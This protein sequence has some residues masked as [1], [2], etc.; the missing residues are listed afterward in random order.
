M[1]IH[2]YVP[3]QNHPEL[4]LTAIQNWSSRRKVLHMG[5]VV[6]FVSV[7]FWFLGTPQVVTVQLRDDLGMDSDD[8]ALSFVFNFIGLGLAGVGLIPL[9]YRY[10]RRSMYLISAL[11]QIG[12]SIWLGSV[13]TK[14][15]YFVCMLIAGMGASVTQTLVP[16]TIADMFFVHQFATMNGWY[17]FAQGTGA[18]LGPAISGKVVKTA[19]WR[20]VWWTHGVVLSVAFIGILFL[21]EESTFVP[22]DREDK[23]NK[24]DG[25]ELFFFNRP[26]S[27][28]S[29]DGA[30]N[31]HVD[32]V[33][34]NR[35]MAMR[36]PELPP[37]PKTLRQR[38]ALITKTKRPIGKRFLA[39]F[40]ILVTFPAVAYVALTYGAVMA[41]LAMFQHVAVTVL[42]KAPYNFDSEGIGLFSLAPFIGHTI[43][44]VVVP[45]LSDRWML[46][47]A[48][49]NGGIYHPE[50]R[51][52]IA[53]PG[54]IFTFIGILMFG[55]S[56]AKRAPWP[57]LAISFAV[58]AFGF[59]IC[60][61]V[62]LAY[63][64]DCYYNVSA[65]GDVT[66][67][68]I[69]DQEITDDW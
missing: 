45:M 31:N 55:L 29:N 8:I 7:T 52:R 49:Q 10:G 12:A 56:T 47:L 27:Y 4:V 61:D 35:T 14:Y 16:M 38:F 63:I 42:G 60:L 53:V 67:V 51:L 33:D 68:A 3:F 46:R 6:V 1:T 37:L 21:L 28:G 59:G 13:T 11:I 48:R 25:E 15:E 2:W 43:G 58:F 24:A 23:K 19:G 66:C 20:W 62:A 5:V 22:N 18:F 34:I 36:V 65:L 30:A 9:A 17:L 39:P 40:V 54:A 26:V 64:S 50:M 44:V 69:A 32:L 41:W 57:A